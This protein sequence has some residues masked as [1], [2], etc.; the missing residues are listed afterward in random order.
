MQRSELIN[1]LKS[2]EA[3]LRGFGVEGLFLFGSHAR[4]E[5]GE[6][7]DVDV[8]VDPASDDFFRLESFMGAYATL[9]KAIGNENLGYGTRGGLS[10]Y[11]RDEVEKQA[12]RI[13]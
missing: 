3:P 6:G 7:S 4:D 2:V 8:F 5:A 12:I 1:R 11:I 13:F 9:Q 10:P